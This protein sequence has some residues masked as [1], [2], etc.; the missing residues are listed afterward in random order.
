MGKYGLPQAGKLTNNDFVLHLV[1]NGYIQSKY[2]AGLFIHTSRP[3]SFCLVVDDFGVKYIGKERAQYFIATQQ[4]KYS[5][6]TDWSGAY[7]WV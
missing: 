1:D 6:T 5:I 3:V 4:S 2:T 7:M